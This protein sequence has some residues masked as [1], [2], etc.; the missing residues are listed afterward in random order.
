VDAFR[1]IRLR[2]TLWYVLLLAIVLAGFSAG[3]FL[4]L[5]HNLYANLDNSLDVRASDLLAAVQF[6][7]AR[8]TLPTTISAGGSEAGEQF[9]RVYDSSGQLTFDNGGEA[10]LIPVD[11][12]AVRQAS[13]GVPSTRVVTLDGDPFRVRIVPIERDGQPMSALEVGRAADDVYDTLNS[14]LLILAIAYPVTLLVASL[15]GLF[16]ASRALSPIDKL[17]RLARRISAADLSQRLDLPL[18]DDEV[19]RLART[20]DE[21]IARLDD[22][23]RRQRQFTADASHELRTPLTAIKGQVEVALDHPRDQPAY[24]EVLRSVNEEVDRLI[25]LVGSL[26]TLAR[27]DAGQVPITLE[28]SNLG[29]LVN[30][31]TEQVR[32]T[33]QQQG[34]D[35]TV[36]PGP[37]L[38]LQADQDLL[39]QLLLNLLDNAIKYTPSGGRITAG[40]GIN[41]KQVELWVRDT[42]VGIAPEHLPRIFDRFYRVDKARSRADGGSGLGLSICRWIAEAHG[43]SISVESIPGQGSTFT[44]HLPM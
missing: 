17:T 16:L 19:G 12:E 31:A 24:Q 40:W 22:S 43:G 10:G 41:G 11:V 28:P 44:V 15:G 3:V 26:L 5:R 1:S 4:T 32:P 18:P 20:L 13:S 37:D 35:L 34:L 30:S 21:M 9:V 8:P 38:T 25:L 29:D 23:F 14:L 36:V 6:E 7:E 33:A 2:L 27:A 42:G 39:L